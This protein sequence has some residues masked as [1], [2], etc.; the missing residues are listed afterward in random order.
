MTPP[1]ALAVAHLGLVE[2]VARQLGLRRSNALEDCLQG[3]RVALLKAAERFDPSYGVAF[4]HFARPAIAGAIKACLCALGAVREPIKRV[5][6]RA[7][8]N[9]RVH[10]V[11]VGA[12]EE[13]A[14]QDGGEDALLERIDQ[15]RREAWLRTQLSQVP[16]AST[17]ALLSTVGGMPVGE[18][19]RRVGVCRNTVTTRA[20]AAMSHLRLAAAR[21]GASSWTIHDLG[22]PEGAAGSADAMATQA[23][24]LA[25]CSTWGRLCNRR[26]FVQ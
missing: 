20:Q 19:A 24:A 26:Q 2:R 9:E 8:R 18:Y 6:Q 22:R 23:S 12:V 7:A 1:H 13:L 15:G 10:P 5:S 14:A 4:P 21:A 25:S 3:G 17:D 16:R 11:T